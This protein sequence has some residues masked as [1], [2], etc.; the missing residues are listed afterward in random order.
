[1]LDIYGGNDYAIVLE[2]AAARRAAGAGNGAYVQ[3]RVDGA[4]HFFTDHNAMLAAS[5]S[6]W[7]DKH[8]RK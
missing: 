7:L 4:N 6:A 1:M 5:V 2:T 8:S 3:Q